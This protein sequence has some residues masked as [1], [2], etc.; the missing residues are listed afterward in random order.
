MYRFIVLAL[1]FVTL[2]SACSPAVSTPAHPSPEPAVPG[3]TMQPAGE[4]TIAAGEDAQAMLSWENDSCGRLAITMETVLYGRCDEGLVASPA[5][6]PA[7]LEKVTHWLETYAAYEAETPAGRVSFHGLGPNA[8]TPAEGR[9]LAEW[10]QL[11]YDIAQSGRTG[12][13][14][15]LAFA[16]SRSGGIAGFCDDVAVYLAGYALVADCQGTNA[17]IDLTATKLEQVYAWFDIY[18]QI[19]YT[20]SE[21][22]VPDA[23]TVALFMPGKGGLQA[24]EATVRAITG[25]AADL[26]AQA[27]FQ[28]QA[29][30]A[31]LEAAE[32]AIEEFLTA[33]NAG[34]YILAA[35]RYGGGTSVLA[36]W[37]PDITNDLPAWLERG[38]TRN[39]LMCLL[40]RS[41]TYRGPDADGALQFL[42]EYNNSDGTLFKQGSCCVEG[43]S[44]VS[45]AFLVRARRQGD[46]WLV[47]DLPPYVP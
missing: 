30:P 24:D 11:T 27:Y 41:I 29:D 43:G 13:A 40:P 18:S 3:P 19:D 2:S 46:L 15:G 6:T 20:Y 16:Y 47:L 34:D 33:L 4:S 39:G 7:S 45:T 8:P 42:V 25:F 23:M 22:A 26:A 5:V 12:A 38:C 35:R 37:N 14:W 28:R 31:E 9:M 36:L 1:C 10:A 17:R 32:A 44:L 21:P